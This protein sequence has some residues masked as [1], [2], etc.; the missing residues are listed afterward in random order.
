ML[1]P[2]DEQIIREAKEGGAVMV[3]WDRVVR[4]A[5]GGLTPYEAMDMALVEGKGTPE[6]KA[7][8]SQLRSLSPQELTS[9]AD[10]GNKTFQLFQRTIIVDSLAAKK[11]RNLRVNERYS[12]RAVARYW[13]KSFGAPWGSNQLAGMV[14]CEK[15]AK[16]LGENFMHQ[17]WN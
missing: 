17:P 16:L 5:A 8:L 2:D 12:W 7:G 9:M 11:I 6:A 4:E 1:D 15:A 3:T 10:A 14:L 13:A